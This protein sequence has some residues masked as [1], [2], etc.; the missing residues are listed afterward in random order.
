M[1]TVCST[2]AG[3]LSDAEVVT[4]ADELI[5][6]YYVHDLAPKQQH[7]NFTQ[8]GVERLTFHVCEIVRGHVK[9]EPSQPDSQTTS[10]PLHTTHIGLTTRSELSR[11]L[12]TFQ[13][14]ALI[15]P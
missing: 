2:E 7:Q 6:A 8:Q 5:Y 1:S 3:Q 12:A 11:Q 10:Q 15:A 4:A 9:K 13:A 14:T